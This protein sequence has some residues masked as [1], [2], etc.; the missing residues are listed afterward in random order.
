MQFNYSSRWSGEEV[1]RGALVLRSRGNISTAVKGESQQRTQAPLH[2][3][4]EEQYFIYHLF[5]CR[6]VLI[7]SV[8]S[9][10]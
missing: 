2:I 8:L 7:N 10:W 5:I 6:Y 4:Q 1:L 9:V 3:K